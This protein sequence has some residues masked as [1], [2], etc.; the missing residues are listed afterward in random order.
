M[1]KKFKSGTTVAFALMLA[2]ITLSLILTAVPLIRQ[3]L[4]NEVYLNAM[5]RCF[6]LAETGLNDTMGKLSVDPNAVLTAVTSSEEGGEYQST[7]YKSSFPGVQNGFYIV[8]SATRTDHGKNYISRLHSYA[9]LSNVGDYFAAVNGDLGISFPADISEGKVYSAGNLTFEAPAVMPPFGA[10]RTMVQS[11]TYVQGST[12]TWT[13]GTVCIDPLNSLNL[14]PPCTTLPTEIPFKLVFPQVLDDD[15]LRYVSL[16]GDHTQ[17]IFKPKIGYG[18]GEI[19]LDTDGLHIFPPGY[20]NSSALLGPVDAY[21]DHGDDNTLHV[22]FCTGTMT[23]EGTIHGQILFVAAEDILISSSVKSYVPPVPLADPDYSRYMPGD[24]VVSSSTAHQAIFITRKNVIIHNSFLNPPATRMIATQ[25]V[26]G[27][28]MAPYGSFY[29]RRYAFDDV[30]NDLIF[31]FRGSMILGNMSSGT[32]FPDIFRR[33]RTYAY[34]NT[35]KTNPPPYIPALID[36][37][38]SFE[39]TI[40]QQLKE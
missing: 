38:H 13:T 32:G 2:A 12:L 19:N 20:V 35:L 16:A 27:L 25:T 7:V 9:Q 31:N 3:N 23:V 18:A 14:V 24:G 5:Y 28:I 21:P 29:P 39:E 33:Q 30:H 6:R 8:T 22:F 36:I 11:A 26:E 34:M 17:C 10:P 15:I 4:D 40:G 37:Y 1:K